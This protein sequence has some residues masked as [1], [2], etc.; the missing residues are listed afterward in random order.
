MPTDAEPAHSDGADDVDEVLRAKY[1]EYC[2]ALLADLLLYLSPDEIYLLAEKATRESESAVQD[3]SYTTMVKRAT[4]L[5]AQRVNLPPFEVW[6]EDYL[7]HRE[8]Y[9]AFFMG[10]WESDAPSRTRR[11]DG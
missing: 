1:L 7:A 6:R 11:L 5:L 3:G 2:S 9:E 10:L 4:G 8:R